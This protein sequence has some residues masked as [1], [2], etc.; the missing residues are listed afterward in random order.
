MKLS[1]TIAVGMFGAAAICTLAG[2]ATVWGVCCDELM[3]LGTCCQNQKVSCASSC[4]L[5]FDA[6][7]CNE[8]KSDKEMRNPGTKGAYGDSST[9]CGQHWYGPPTESKTCTNRCTTDSGKMSRYTYE[10]QQC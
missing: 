6:S 2:A 9:K 3:V 1:R 5:S 7:Q 8:Y 10:F 4:T